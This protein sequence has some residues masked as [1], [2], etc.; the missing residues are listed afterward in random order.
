MTTNADAEKI[1]T[2]KLLQIDEDECRSFSEID[3]EVPPSMYMNSNTLTF[4]PGAQIMMLVN[5]EKYKNGSLGTLVDRDE[6]EEIA[7]VE[8]E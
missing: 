8:I 6:D 2:K 1:N 4:K 3:G 5:G 7:R